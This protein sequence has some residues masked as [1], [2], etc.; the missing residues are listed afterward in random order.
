MGLNLKIRVARAIT[1]LIT[2]KELFDIICQIMNNSNRHKGL[3]LSSVRKK[4]DVCT[5]FFSNATQSQPP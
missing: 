3:W 2:Y 5:P 4:G 1:L